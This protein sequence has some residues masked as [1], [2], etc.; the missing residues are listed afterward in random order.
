MK[1]DIHINITQERVSIQ[2][3]QVREHLS[4]FI[5]VMELAS[6]NNVSANVNFIELASVSKLI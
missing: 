2:Y 6:Y 4:Q 1:G 3:G 5:V